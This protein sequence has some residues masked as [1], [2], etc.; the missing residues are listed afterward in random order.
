MHRGNFKI[1]EELETLE[2]LDECAVLSQSG[3]SLALRFSRGAD[4]AVDATFAI[5]EGRLVARFAAAAGEPNRFLIS[6]PAAVS[7]H[8]Y[9]CGEQFSYLDLRGHDF[10]LW[11]SEQG[12]G[13]NKGTRITRLAD[14]DDGAGGDYY[15]TFFPQTSFVSSAGYWCHLDTS[16]YA[17]FDFRA[18]DRHDLYSWAIPERLVIGGADTMRDLVSDLSAYFGRQGELPDWCYDGAILGVQGGTAVCREKLAAAQKAGV[19]VAGLWAQ[20]WEGINM[21]PP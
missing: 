17:D 1:T 5:E 8:V 21:L 19:K 6:L 11:T 18:D 14:A 4:L 9:G 13:R 3:S 7:E 2:A 10:P 15:W 20:D 12:V 16:A